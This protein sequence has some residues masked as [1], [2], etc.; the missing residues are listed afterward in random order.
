MVYL[1]LYSTLTKYLKGNRVGEAVPVDLAA[2]ANIKDLI[3]KLGI[4]R[5]EVF[6]VSVNG[7]I[8]G[9]DYVLREGD[10]VSLFGPVAGGTT[11]GS[12]ARPAGEGGH[13]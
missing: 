8:E 12:L 7:Q 9:H 3:G 11:A 6:L 10:E 13:Q 4:A 2:G 5:E 1:R